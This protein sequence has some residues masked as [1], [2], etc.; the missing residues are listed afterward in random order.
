MGERPPDSQVGA[1]TWSP[2]WPG[3]QSPTLSCRGASAENCRVLSTQDEATLTRSG[4]CTPV[5]V[6][7]AQELSA[8][9]LKGCT[10]PGSFLTVGEFAVSI[11]FK[12]FISPH[13]RALVR[14]RKLI[15]KLLVKQTKT[16]PKN[17]PLR[18]DHR[19]LNSKLDSCNAWVSGMKNKDFSFMICG[20]SKYSKLYFMVFSL[21]WFKNKACVCWAG[22]VTKNQHQQTNEKPTLMK[23]KQLRGTCFIPVP[24]DAH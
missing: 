10:K 7:R 19:T 3:P 13:I 6:H 24:N 18:L 11:L 21:F 9:Q 2:S 23:H 15:A 5:A 20:V 16:K 12:K 1:A 14:T 17:T 4:I 8:R 22:V